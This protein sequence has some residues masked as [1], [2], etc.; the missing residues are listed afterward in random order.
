MLHDV[1]F[2]GLVSLY[3]HVKWISHCD[4]PG[5]LVRTMITGSIGVQRALPA[6]APRLRAGFYKP[7]AVL[8]D[9]LQRLS[10]KSPEN[11]FVFLHG[12]PGIGKTALAEAVHGKCAEVRSHC[13][14]GC[15]ALC[16]SVQLSGGGVLQQVVREHSI[17]ADEGAIS[18]WSGAGAVGPGAFRRACMVH[19]QT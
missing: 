2:S 10:A 8:E 5:L 6:A 12:A 1:K 13:C 9:V 14:L 16:I 11:H 15:G 7:P 3:M 19:Q 18:G 4:H 17:C